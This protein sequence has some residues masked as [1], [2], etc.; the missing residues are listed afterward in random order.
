MPLQCRRY[1][2]C[3]AKL[4]G[5]KRGSTRIWYDILSHSDRFISDPPVCVSARVGVVK[6]EVSS[7]GVAPRPGRLNVRACSMPGWTGTGQSWPIFES[8]MQRRALW[9]VRG[10]PIFID[11]C[12]QCERPVYL[13]SLLHYSRT[14]NVGRPFLETRPRPCS[15]D[16]PDGRRAGSRTRI[17]GRP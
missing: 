8:L 4:G 1:A 9:E 7:A 11:H 16:G 13:A 17:S 10:W 5:G 3:H 15:L 12:D 2:P 6:R 14:H